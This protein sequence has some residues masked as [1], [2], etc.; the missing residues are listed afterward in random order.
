MEFPDCRCLFENKFDIC[1]NF[2]AD[3]SF[4]NNHYKVKL[5][6]IPEHGIPDDD[7]LLCKNQLNNL[8]NGKFRKDQDLFKRYNEIIILR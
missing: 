1:E 4:P 2:E 3:I 8:F 5:L 6:F 7:F